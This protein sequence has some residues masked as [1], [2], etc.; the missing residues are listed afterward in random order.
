MKKMFFLLLFLAVV[1][2]LGYG[3]YTGMAGSELQDKMRSAVDTVKDKIDD[4]QGG[5]TGTDPAKT[6][7]AG[8]EGKSGTGIA[9]VGT[10][11]TQPG[12]T[13]ESGDSKAPGQTPQSMTDK[14]AQTVLAAAEKLY[15]EAQFAGAVEKLQSVL[16]SSVEKPLEERAARLSGR[17]RTFADVLDDIPDNQRANP[18]NMVDVVLMSGN[19]MRGMLVADTPGEVRI[20]RPGGLEMGIRKSQVKEVLKLDLARVHEQLE[21]ELAAQLKKRSAP[22]ATDYYELAVF[23][24]KNRLDHRVAEMLEKALEKDPN[25]NKSLHHQKAKN[26]YEAYVWFMGRGN[27]KDAKRLQDQLTAK[28]ADTPYAKML[29]E[30]IEELAAATKGSTAGGGGEG[31]LAAGDN[32]GSGS[33]AGP[34]PSS[35]ATEQVKEL[36]AKANK[37]YDEGMDH[38]NRA[39]PGSPNRKEENQ[40]A[41]QCFNQS[42]GLYE[43]AWALSGGDNALARRIDQVRS[44]KVLTFRRQK[45]LN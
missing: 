26:M 2:G 36:V 7:A 8:V 44:V 18:D 17:A 35:G 40:K 25:L 14:A 42:L 20:R 12:T 9:T 45:A 10:T 29:Q 23:C 28:Y 3:V 21:G 27:Q 13:P 33:E 22:T 30:T 16:N 11:K 41:F 6:P 43:E 1:G 38:F 24:Y 34:T 32:G 19:T 15:K 39:E 5:V 31:P 37:L 4:A